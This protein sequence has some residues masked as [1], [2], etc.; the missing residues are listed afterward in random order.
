MIVASLSCYICRR[1]CRYN[2]Y[3][4]TIAVRG[5]I[6]EPPKDTAA[7]GEINVEKLLEQVSFEAGNQSKMEL[8]IDEA[9]VR[10]RL[11]ELAAD[12]DLSRYVL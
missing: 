12:E 10:E 4:S 5:G 6:P 9:Y 2:V 11:G 3:K 1:I 8:A 7:M